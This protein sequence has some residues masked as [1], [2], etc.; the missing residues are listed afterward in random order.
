MKL[1]ESDRLFLLTVFSVSLGGAFA[2]W[3]LVG[4]FSAINGFV[5]FMLLI[6]LLLFCS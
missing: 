4:L 2:L 6:I 3:Y 5:F 1:S